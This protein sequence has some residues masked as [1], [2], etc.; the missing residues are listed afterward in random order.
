MQ[1]YVGM[2]EQEKTVPSLN[3]RVVAD[4]T[5]AS[6]DDYVLLVG[7]NSKLTSI[8]QLKGKKVAI[9][10][11][12]FNFGALALDVLLKPYHMSS[13]DYT[14]VVLPFSDAQQALAKERGR[15]RL[16]DRAVHHDRGGRR[17]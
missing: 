14:T 10:A 4:D 1:N 7:K 6:L 15:C 11:P 12:G 17:G 16:H 13:A 8:S 9:P 2:L 3:Q 5:Q